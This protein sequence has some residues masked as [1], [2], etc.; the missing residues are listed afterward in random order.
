[1]HERVPDVAV[2]P[3]AGSALMRQRI[4]QD[5]CFFFV[6]EFSSKQLWEQVEACVPWELRRLCELATVVDSASRKESSPAYVCKTELS[7]Y[8]GDGR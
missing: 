8:G 6:N 2:L 4:S 1:M 3:A 5:L 7:W